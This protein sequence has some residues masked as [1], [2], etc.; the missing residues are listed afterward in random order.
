MRSTPEDKRQKEEEDFKRRELEKARLATLKEDRKT[1]MLMPEFQRYMRDVLA[2]GGM[3]HSVMTGNSH[4]YYKSGQQDFCR[5]I[6]TDLLQV[7]QQ[8]ALDLLKPETNEE[9]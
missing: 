8:G 4:T 7:D 1:L 3:F 2:R 9:E 6:W 5:L